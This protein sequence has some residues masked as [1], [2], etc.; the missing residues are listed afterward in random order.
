[1]EQRIILLYFK[2]AFFFFNPKCDNSVFP[3]SLMHRCYDSV[4]RVCVNC[5]YVGVRSTLDS[6][7]NR[8]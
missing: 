7:L 3:L 6:S 5:R 4:A 2:E 8:K 1:M